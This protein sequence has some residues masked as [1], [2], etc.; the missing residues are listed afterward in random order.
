MIG[1][2]G[3]VKVDQNFKSLLTQLRGKVPDQKAS[4]SNSLIKRIFRWLDPE[5]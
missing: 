3:K 5:Y 1:Y 4:T 2:A